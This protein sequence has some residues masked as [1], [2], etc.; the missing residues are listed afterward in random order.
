MDSLTFMITDCH[1]H[2]QPIEMFKPAAL[3]VMKKKRANFDEIV[4]FCRSP[5]KFLH[6]LD[7]IGVDRAVLINYVAPDLMGFTSGVNEFVANYVKEN[8]KRLIPCGSVHPRHT[9]NVE[10]DMEQIVRLGIR[11]IKVH[12]PHQLLYPNDYLNGM[13]ELETV[14]RVAEQSGIPVMV[15][16]GTSIFPGARNKYGD[17]IYV[18][19]VAVDFPK[20]KIILAHGGRPLWME[21]AFFLVRRHPNVYLDISGIPPKTLLKYFPRLQE[22]ADKTLFGTDWP[23]PGVPEIKQNLEDFR[24]LPITDA[25]K[26]QILGKTA[27]SIW[28]S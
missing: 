18:D 22:I 11:M 21:T 13:K 17:P 19:D 14:Y 28:P 15:H 1:V 2:I 10:G 3:A 20:L 5:K 4:E 8:P 23:G 27:L 26:Q 7:Q 6:H 16:T 25:A 12:P 9:A 24:S